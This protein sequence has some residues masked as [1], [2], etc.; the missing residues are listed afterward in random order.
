MTET[1]KAGSGLHTVRFPNEN[2]GYREARDA[3]L[4]AEIELRR[5]IE[6]VAA[7]RRAL[8]PGG[9]IPEDYL[10]EELDRATGEGRPVRMSELFDGR[11][12]LIA[13]SF[14]FGPAMTRAC[15]SCTSIIDSLDGASDHVRQRMELV[16]IAKSPLPRIVEFAKGRGWRH[17]RLL[18]SAGNSYN[19]D[20]RGEDEEG[21]QWPVLNVFDREGGAIRHRFASELL[22]VPAEPGQDGRHVDLIW[23][24]WN[25]FDFT[26]EG[27]GTD[28]RPRLDYPA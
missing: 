12:T 16:V 14:M 7:Q 25:L 17:V 22:F 4:R 27:R 26:P 28:W 10:F 23:P 5:Q 24:L 9:A 21:A 19:R 13:Y 20:Y 15:P 6:T 8:P 18:S 1:A 2:A 11:A 3:L